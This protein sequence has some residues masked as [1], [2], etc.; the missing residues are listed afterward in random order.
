MQLWIHAM[1]I[2]HLQI[3]NT[4][5]H[6]LEISFSG[7]PDNVDDNQKEMIA[8]ALLQFVKIHQ[9]NLCQIFE[10]KKGIDKYYITY[11][12]N[13]AAGKA[14][15]LKFDGNF[16]YYLMLSSI[17]P[18][19]DKFKKKFEKKICSFCEVFDLTKDNFSE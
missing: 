14:V 15:V 4:P 10:N 8:K 11:H 12:E 5:S 16:N 13:K 18:V 7:N 6:D 1:S 3:K 9:M 2:P 17:S 19:D